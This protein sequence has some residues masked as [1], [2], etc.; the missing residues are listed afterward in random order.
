VG[1]TL[2]VKGISENGNIRVDLVDQWLR[3]LYKIR[4]YTLDI[5]Q[6]QYEQGKNLVGVNKNS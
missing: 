2:P 1:K 3:H 5:N 6:H 4:D